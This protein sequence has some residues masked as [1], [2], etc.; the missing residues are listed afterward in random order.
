MRRRV[1]GFTLVEIMVVVGII[2]LLAALAIPSFLPARAATQ[3]NVCINNLR[4]ISS[5]KAQWALENR[6]KEG[7]DV[8]EAALLNYLKRG[9]EL[10]TCP[11]GGNYTVNVVGVEPTCSEEGHILH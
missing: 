7:D 8:D 9:I 11:A 6:A 4:Q 3:R 2:G 1:E 10:P 5:A